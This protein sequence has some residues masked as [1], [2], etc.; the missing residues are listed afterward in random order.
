MSE[1]DVTDKGTR[2]VTWQRPLLIRAIVLASLVL[3]F[4]GAVTP[5][6]TTER[7]YFFANTFS[8]ASGLRQLFV[9]GQWVLAAVIGLFSLCIPVVKAAVVWIAAGT[10][11]RGGP[12]LAIADRFGK[13]S[14]LEVFIAALLIIALKLGP[15]VDTE[16]HYGAYL[17]AASVLLS[18]LAS[19][20][21]VRH[22][23]DKPIF[24]SPV[25]LTVGAVVGAASATGLIA[26]L[27]PD[28]LNFDA[29]IGTPETRCVQR[30]LRL[31]Q[32]YARTT[33][34]H[35]EYVARLAGI[36]T[37]SCP[38]AF[39]DAFDD[40]VD[41]WSDLEASDARDGAEPSWLD[42][43]RTLLGLAP[44]RDEALE[45]IEEAWAEIERVAREHDVKPPAK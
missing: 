19:Q 26:L 35:S 18:G 17:L 32:T 6:L 5:L 11:G 12:L 42:R 23:G 7:F 45:D 15:V 27:N 10:H 21:L 28:L 24:A 36:D 29:L 33:P 43:T 30:A 40:Y 2:V 38:E 34:E 3:L 37:A 8:L 39:R 44:T 22:P 20:L 14:M 41:A 4:T 25:P 16:L 9:N 1:N 13:W 31:D